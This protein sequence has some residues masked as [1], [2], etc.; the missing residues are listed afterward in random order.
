MRIFIWHFD[1]IF[2]I[3]LIQ[4]ELAGHQRMPLGKGGCLIGSMLSSFLSL[5]GQTAVLELADTRPA[6]S[7]GYSS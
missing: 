7:M 2:E 4:L 5:W 1:S 6:C 3:R